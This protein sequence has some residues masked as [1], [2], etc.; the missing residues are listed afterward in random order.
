LEESDTLN[1]GL[2][3]WLFRAKNG[4]DWE[5]TR[6]T[7]AAIELLKKH[8]LTVLDAPKTLNVSV[9]G[10][11]LSVSDD[12]LSGI[13]YAFMRTKERP[14]SLIVNQESDQ[15]NTG[16]L[17]WYYFTDSTHPELLNQQI[18]VKKQLY[19]LNAAK[20]WIPIAAMEV[21]KVGEK[22]RVSLTVETA[23]ALKYVYIDDKRPAAF[24]PIVNTSGY[25]YGNGISYYRSVRDSGL[26]IFAESI[27][28][29]I[30]EITYELIVAQEGT[31]FNA[32]TVLQCMY[33]PAVTAYSNSGMIKSEK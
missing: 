16:A 30:S 4:H 3:K 11:R 9:A 18:K 2:I 1:A 15:E 28:S 27:T 29:G 20:L 10:N 13:P 14:A 26:Q 25:E 21:L 23:K 24:E 33:Q 6:A 5:S 22:I 8:K 12:L 31:F 17:T 7:A 19:K 32:P